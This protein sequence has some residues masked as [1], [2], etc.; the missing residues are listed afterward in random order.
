LSAGQ[1]FRIRGIVVGQDRP[2]DIVVEA[3]RVARIEPAGAAPADFGSEDAVIAPALFD[4]QVNGAMGIDLQGRDVRAE[5]V[6]ALTDSLAAQGVARWVPTLITASFEDMRHGCRVVAEALADPVVRRA[7]PGLHLEGPYISP[8]DGPR[9]A[10]PQRHVRPPDLDEFDRL[11]EAADGNILYVTV[12]PE[13]EGAGA[14]IKALV[15]RGVA[16]SLGHHNAGETDIAAAVDAGAVLCTHLG[17]GLASEIHRH[18]NPLW[19]QLA[20]D[21]LAASLIADL[22]HLPPPMLKSLVRAKGPERVVLTSDCVHIAGL[23]P[24]EYRLGGHPVELTT[25][26]RIRLSGT[27]LLAGSSLM[28]LQG[29]VNAADVAGLSLEQAFAC[30]TSVPA[31]LF[32][33]EPTPW[34]PRA[35][36]PANLVAFG[37]DRSAS[38]ERA[39]V[40][41]VFIDGERRV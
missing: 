15:S 22:E 7:V 19:P 13:W 16:V 33:Q 39:E 23:P 5:D 10:H 6:R 35:G 34:P 17:N 25:Y 21:R 4:I 12:A 26:G 31:A 3:G 37:L 38:P 20:E 27:D 32:G 1:R 9:G 18:W 28:L 36:V 11:L 14:F 41:C 40:E 2:S 29:V 30:A 8:E 24:G